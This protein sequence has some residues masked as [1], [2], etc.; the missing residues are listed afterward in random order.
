MT[1]V[2]DIREQATAALFT[3]L[4]GV[5]N[6]NSKQRRFEMWDSIA[7]SDRPALRFLE[8]GETVVRSQPAGLTFIELKV[9]AALYW[10]VPAESAAVPASYMN[11]VLASLDLKM[12]P[13][14]ATQRLDLGL[15]PQVQ[16]CYI[17]G[18]VIK[19]P[20]DLDSVGLA[21]VPIKI[22]LLP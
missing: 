4:S 12:R 17:E 16:D 1:T 15:Y 20:G 8:N 9:S 22:L 6:F 7:A 14:L 10:D 3:L 21:I 2:Y 11:T 5:V 19:D 18:E 13:N